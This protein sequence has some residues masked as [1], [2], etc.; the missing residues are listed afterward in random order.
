MSK[1]LVMRSGKKHKQE[2][3]AVRRELEHSQEQSSQTA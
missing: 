3:N 1:R 2:K